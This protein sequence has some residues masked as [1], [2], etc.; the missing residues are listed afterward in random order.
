MPQKNVLLTGPPGVGKTTIIQKVA[1][2]LGDRAAGFYTVETRSGGQRTGFR[3]V[4]LDGREADLAKVGSGAGP[5]VGRYVVDLIGIEQVAVPSVL[6]GLAEGKVIVVDEIGKMELYSV[7]FRN[8]VLRALSSPI[9][10]IA[11]IMERPNDFCDMVKGR[12]DVVLFSTSLNNRNEMPAR[13]LGLLR[14][15]L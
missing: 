15:Y 11:T 3:I 1:K 8:A 2:E 5:R 7:A 12:P 10:V 9:P 4:T 6:Y 13:I 14:T